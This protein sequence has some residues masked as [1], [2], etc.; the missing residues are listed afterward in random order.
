MSSLKYIHIFQELFKS[1][2]NFE[3]YEVGIE[4][5]YHKKI[6]NISSWF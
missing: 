5:D 6:E 2:A 1:L 3:L 4:N